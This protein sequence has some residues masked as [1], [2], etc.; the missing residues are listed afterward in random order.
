MTYQMRTNVLP[1]LLSLPLIALA[2]CSA[3]DG[4]PTST[5][6]AAGATQSPSATTAPAAAP[7]ATKTPS[8]S[9]APRPALIDAFT[10]TGLLATPR[11][12]HTATLL[13]GGRVLVAGGSNITEG[14]LASAKIYEPDRTVETTLDDPLRP[15]LLQGAFVPTGS[16]N[17]G[18]Q[19]H[20]AT[21]L[22][23]GRVLVTG[24]VGI[25]TS[26]GT[27]EAIRLASAEIYD[28][29]TGT[30][31]PAGS[32]TEPRLAHASTL[33]P[34]GRVLIVGGFGYPSLATAELYDPAT[35]AFT[36]TGSMRRGVQFPSIVPLPDGRVL[37][38]GGVLPDISPEIYDPAT[39]TFSALAIPG[40]VDDFDW[41]AQ[42]I[43]LED[44]RTLLTGGCCG[45]DG[46]SNLPSAAILDVAAS[47]IEPLSPMSEGRVAHQSV[48]LL[49]GRVLI[50]GGVDSAQE[51]AERLRSAELFDPATGSFT[52]VGPMSDGRHWHSLSLLSDGRVLVLGSSALPYQRA[53]E[54]FVPRP[55]AAP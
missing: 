21:R 14:L 55:L 51:G 46:I 8:T 17:E 49:D 18:R 35:D 38:Y 10:A 28:P 27:N 53:A 13:E 29:R 4:S 33:L 47:T 9:P 25:L 3:G 1:L 44:G 12:L 2:A 26:G 19:T 52:A 30:F 41:P 20:A 11:F 23:D 36:R 32:M 45:D 40:L 39:G 22:A 31:E 34:D 50:T 6:L 24:G 42:A 48:L 37:V 5:P 7:A 43:G 15:A 54:L 16:L